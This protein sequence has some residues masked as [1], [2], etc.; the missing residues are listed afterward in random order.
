MSVKWPELIGKIMVTSVVQVSLAALELPPRIGIRKY[1]TTQ[2][3]ARAFIGEMHAYIFIATIWAIGTSLLVYVSHYHLGAFLN[4]FMNL[5]IM[6][7]IVSRR[8]TAYKENI[9]K[10]SLK[11]VP[12]ISNVF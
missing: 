5:L 6:Y 3:D 7:W 11:L 12:L 4:L 1:V 2:D 10:Y 8:Y 9:E